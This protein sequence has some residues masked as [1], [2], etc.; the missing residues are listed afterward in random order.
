[1][2]EATM[3]INSVNCVILIGAFGLIIFFYLVFIFLYCIMGGCGMNTALGR[4]THCVHSWPLK[5]L[6]QLA[7][8][9]AVFYALQDQ[10]TSPEPGGVLQG[11]SP[12]LAVAI[13]GLVYL[14]YSSLCLYRW[15]HTGSSYPQSCFSPQ[16]LKTFLTRVQESEPRCAV[17]VSSWS[18]LC[19]E[20]NLTKDFQPHLWT[21]FTE[22][23][24]VVGARKNRIESATNISDVLE[25][26]L[27]RH[28]VLIVDISTEVSPEDDLSQGNTKQFVR[29]V[30][31][32]ALN[33]FSKIS[34]TSMVVHL[35]AF[36]GEQVVTKLEMQR[37][38]RR[39]AVKEAGQGEGGKASLD[40]LESLPLSRIPGPSLTAIVHRE[41]DL[42]IFWYI[43]WKYK[44]SLS[45]PLILLPPLGTCFT[46]IF[47]SLV[48]RHNLDISIKYSYVPQT[49]A[50][51]QLDKTVPDI[52][53]EEP[54]KVTIV[55]PSER[56]LVPRDSLSRIVTG[57]VDWRQ[58][59]PL[60]R[61]C[62]TNSTESS[63][64]ILSPHVSNSTS[65]RPWNVTRAR[66]FQTFPPLAAIAPLNVSEEPQG[67]VPPSY[68]AAVIPETVTGVTPPPEYQ[69][70]TGSSSDQ[71]SSF[72]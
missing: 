53:F 7:S 25:E 44:K 15:F 60:S 28:R 29:K 51:Y 71:R 40:T 47:E 68:T 13:L 6:L 43:V 26:L 35:P 52:D 38:W 12:S 39:A 54:Q 31:S 59:G 57:E 34:N 2:V 64:P 9:G 11:A 23:I 27:R 72:F 32:S 24:D 14:L 37:S 67:D 19:P 56:F 49:E 41:M 58:E 46:V 55:M 18:Y 17:Q 4:L 48:P 21:E 70:A 62:R 65:P 5:I 3:G 42:P 1:M 20:D 50:P 10:S 33:Q 45:V 36:S 30:L 63:P 22:S 61:L 66:P 16:E 69:T 8:Y